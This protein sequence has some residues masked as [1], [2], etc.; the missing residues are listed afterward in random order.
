MVG[1]VGASVK[2]KHKPNRA[3]VFLVAAAAES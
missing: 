1:A 2:P 3:M